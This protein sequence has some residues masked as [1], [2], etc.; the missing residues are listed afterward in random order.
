MEL[1]ASDKKCLDDPV[2]FVARD[3]SNYLVVYDS[4][5]ITYNL[6]GAVFQVTKLEVR[7]HWDDGT[8]LVFIYCV[9]DDNPHTAEFRISDIEKIL[10]IV[11]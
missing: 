8:C 10:K 4:K 6:W 3:G 5:R 7:K 2:L 9:K 11:N 1:V